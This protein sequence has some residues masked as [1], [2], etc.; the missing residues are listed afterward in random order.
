MCC[1]QNQDQYC[2]VY[3]NGMA[4][5]KMNGLKLVCVPI[6]EYPPPMRLH[7]TNQ[8]KCNMH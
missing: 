2:S 5:T 3:C 6:F 1:V 7:N 8:H 4:F